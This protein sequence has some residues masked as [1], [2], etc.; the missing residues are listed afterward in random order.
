M[1]LLIAGAGIGGLTAAIA[2]A[3]RGHRVR[4]VEKSASHAALGAGIVLGVNAI[5]VLRGLGVDLGVERGLAR[6][7]QRLRICTAAGAP[8]QTLDVGA[9]GLGDSY[10][11]A[12]PELHELLLEALPDSVRVSLDTAIIALQPRVDNVAVRLSP[13][14]ELDVDLVIGA[15]GIHSAVR[16]SLG[17]PA[18]LRYSGVTCYRAVV[19]CAA[20][21]A[22]W[23]DRGGMP[24]AAFSLDEPVEVWG[25]NARVGVVPLTRDRLYVYLVV[26]AP[27]RAPALAPDALRAAFAHV[28]GP[29]AGV[30]DAVAD[31]SLLHHDLNELDAPVWGTPRVP[32]LGDAAHAMTPNQGQGAAMAIEDAVALADALE[33]A[34]PAA[35]LRRYVKIRQARVRK[36]QLDSRRIG[37]VA[38]WTNPIA[39]ALRDAALRSLPDSASR[40]QM[41]SLIRPGLALLKA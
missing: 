7:V 3:R 14:E 15:D 37:V 20:A 10:A 26:A 9:L 40:R 23:P 11:Y 18:P 33:L 24:R 19:D 35:A 29:V 22:K 34:D 21:R 28:R 39:T 8:L 38:H 27:A 32:L 17:L 1:N 6:R 41:Q 4:V 36:V 13:G 12:R 31:L 25:G 30:V 2:L 5:G 16:T